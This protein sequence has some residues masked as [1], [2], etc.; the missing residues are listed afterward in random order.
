MRYHDFFFLL[1][2]YHP[3]P[4]VR[5]T[6]HSDEWMKGFSSVFVDVPS[7]GYGTRLVRWNSYSVLLHNYIYIY[8]NY[9]I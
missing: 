3:D 4:N 1:S 9:Y 7:S 8:N 2:S 5:D 6:G